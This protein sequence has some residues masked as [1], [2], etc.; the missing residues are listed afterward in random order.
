MTATSSQRLNLR[1][2]SRSMPTSSNPQAAWSAREAVA[3]GLDAGHHG[4]E[5]G[6]GSATSTSASSRSVPTPRPVRSRRRTPSPPPSCG[7]PPAPCTATA[8]RTRRPRR[9]RRLGDDGAKAP[10]RAGQPGS[11]VVQRA[12]HQV[13]RG[14]GVLDLVVV[15]GPDRPRRRRRWPAG[16]VIVAGVGHRR[17]DASGLGRRRT[18]CRGDR[19]PGPA[20]SAAA[21]AMLARRSAALPRPPS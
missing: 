20:W 6:L 2:T 12:G 17:G 5:A 7:R 16:C 11:L 13:E 10:D 18:P 3:A 1:P 8:R 4:V 19:R 9:R 15:D 14:R 21:A